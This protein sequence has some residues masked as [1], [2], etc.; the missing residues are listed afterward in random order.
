M[1]TK[2]DKTGQCRLCLNNRILCDSHIIPE[3]FFKKAYNDKSFMIEA[4]TDE[5]LPT[6]RIRKGHHELIL[7]RKC[8]DIFQ[9]YESEAVRLRDQKSVTF[10][11]LEGSVFQCTGMD[12]KN[13]KLFQLSVLW[14]MSVSTLD[15][16]NSVNVGPY[17]EKLRQM[18]LSGDPGEIADFGCFI[19]HRTYEGEAADRFLLMPV[20]A[21]TLNT[22]PVHTKVSVWFGGFIWEYIVTLNDK[23][24]PDTAALFLQKDGSFYLDTEDLFASEATRHMLRELTVSVAKR[25]QIM[26]SRRHQGQVP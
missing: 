22:V 15:Q 12:Y 16:Y 4:S 5:N 11:H 6:K 20:T 14:R 8:E 26:N 23:V 7:C 21:K 18:L 24:N 17:Q 10:S 3:M 19:G 1:K 25:R 13:F 2:R 9:I